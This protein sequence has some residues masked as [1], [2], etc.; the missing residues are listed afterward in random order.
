MK[1]GIWHALLAVMLTAAVIVLPVIRSELTEGKVTAPSGVEKSK[2][3]IIESSDKEPIQPRNNNTEE[4]D[5]KV[6]FMVTLEEASVID[7]LMSS[8]GK[9][10]NVRELILSADGKSYCDAIKK[11]QAVAKA[12]IKKLVPE[13]D[14]TDSRTFSALFNGITVT[15]PLSAREKLERIKGVSAVCLLEDDYVLFDRDNESSTSGEESVSYEESSA[16]EESVSGQDKGAADE[17]KEASEKTVSNAGKE[18]STAALNAQS[19]RDA[20]LTLTGLDA[21]DVE[22]YSGKGSLIAVIDN[23]FDTASEVFSEYP[24]V[25]NVSPS[26]IS[27]LYKRISFNTSA[28]HGTADVYHSPKIVFAYDYAQNDSD[29][30]DSTV[31]HG[32]AAASLAAGNNGDEAAVPFRG[33][34]YDAQLALM[35]VSDSEKGIST[36]AFISALDDTVKLGADIVN[37]SF[38][39]FENGEATEMILDAFDKMKYAGIT[40][41]A[42]AGNGAY[43]GYDIGRKPAAADIFYSAE[44]VL[45][46]GS[47]VISAG[48]SENS[49]T[50]RRSFTVNGTKIYYKDIGGI[51]LASTVRYTRNIGNILGISNKKVQYNEYVFADSFNADEP[52]ADKELNGKLLILDA[53]SIKE[54]DKACKTAIE[55]G[56]SAI[57]ITNGRTGTEI[58]ET[59][60]IPV[61]IAQEDNK[62]LFAAYPDGTFTVDIDGE[63]TKKDS[64]D[65]ISEFTSYGVSDSLD[66]GARI[67]A[68]GE[69]ILAA[70]ADGGFELVSGTSVSAPC[71][72][73]AYAV[74]KQYIRTR[75]EYSG[76]SDKD[77]PDIT[78][79]VMLSCSRPVVYSEKDGEKLYYSPRIQGFGAIDIKNAAEAQAH[80]T[81]L[82]GISGI[83][84]GDGENDS[85]TFIFYLTNDSAEQRTFNLSYVL[86]TDRPETGADGRTINSLEPMS[87]MNSSSMSFFIND[88]EIKELTL[89]AGM[90]A[91]ITAVMTVDSNAMAEHKKDFPN[92]FYLDGYVFVS[93][94]STNDIVLPFM[95]FYGILADAE[96]FD[97]TVYDIEDSVTGLKSSFVSVAFKNGIPAA[98]ELIQDED[99]LLFS[100]DLV[101]NVEDD[102]YYGN[103][104]ILPELYTLCSVY[105]LNVAVYDSEGKRIYYEILGNVSSHR[106]ADHR[107]FEQLRVSRG[108]REFF[109]RL[110]SGRYKYEVGARIM[111]PDGTLSAE[112]RLSYWFELDNVRPGSV[113]SAVFSKNGRLYLDLTAADSSGIMGFVLYGAAYDKKNDRYDY[114]DSLDRIISAGYISEN[115]YTFIEK[116]LN[117]D[118]SFTFRYDITGLSDELKKLSVNTDTWQ[119]KSSYKKIA[120]RAIDCAGNSSE[121]RLADAIECG[122]AEF[123]FTDQNGRPAADI[124]VKIGRTTLYSDSKGK[125]LFDKLEP[126][127][128]YAKLIYDEN[129]YSIDRGSYLVSITKT[130]LSYR[131]EQEAVF[132]GTYPEGQDSDNIVIEK[133]NNVSFMDEQD[134]DVPVYAFVFVGT[135]LAV[136]IMLF[137]LRKNYNI[138]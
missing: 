81:T 47:G 113:D 44:N 83:K 48:S 55:K 65:R 85:R 37:I 127:Y 45:S 117:E 24:D 114:I 39:S 43:N 67:T 12:S 29:T 33:I 22:E 94:G 40:V 77:I 6:L 78:R 1:K 16:Q 97:N 108:L 49:V 68:P 99:R 131:A 89:G 91:G 2:R 118:G 26:V 52:F 115:A 116:I 63:V 54:L 57:A 35:K 102:S 61:V 59:D 79:S 90:S 34:A 28:G 130:A 75:D 128:Y 112:R 62:K 135:M 86:Q 92:G 137:I 60:N 119:N 36:A 64:Y 51:K 41:V 132:Y 17:E 74:L 13:A 20:Y 126:G 82:G 4:K 14:L 122:S 72:S 23:E 111:L 133:T 98:C 38:G 50:V 32:T 106:N 105:D 15:A 27:E 100:P 31:S 123:V 53:G 76:L 5:E 136:C 93:A 107:P 109:G 125:I 110:S 69:E 73:G 95:G 58:E 46:A 70:G 129:L 10:N 8:G 11:S 21:P 121:V 42:A 96:P 18:K 71:I 101:R 124:G 138:L 25:D 9:N 103:S 66:I 7:R 104:V 88:E 84:L 120:Y 30:S 3:N 80:I 87:L 19:M 134:K 56:A